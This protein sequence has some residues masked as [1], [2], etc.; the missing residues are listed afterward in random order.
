MINMGA[1]EQ[2]VF[3]LVQTTFKENNIQVIVVDD[4]KSS[5]YS[6]KS[7][8]FDSMGTIK[9]EIKE[10]I[11]SN[12]LKHNAVFLYEVTSEQMRKEK[13]GLVEWIYTMRFDLQ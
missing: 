13:G 4:L 1:K 7:R 10:L 2:R 6:L 5:L 8:K 11:K 9:E 3:D 12:K